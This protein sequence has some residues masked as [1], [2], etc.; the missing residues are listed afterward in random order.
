MNHINFKDEIYKT[1]W[2]YIEQFIANGKDP[3]KILYHLDLCCENIRELEAIKSQAEGLIRDFKT[4]KKLILEKTLE[5][6][7][8]DLEK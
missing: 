3:N 4:C 8:K 6:K 7:E 1:F 2:P 5:Q